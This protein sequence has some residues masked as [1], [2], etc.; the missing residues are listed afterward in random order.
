MPRYELTKDHYLQD[1][2][3]KI[4]PQLHEAGSKV[5]WEGP[6]SLHMKPL[7]N[8]ATERVE[9]RQAA[10][11][12]KREKAQAGRAMAGWTPQFGANMAQIITRTTSPEAPA[13]ADAGSGRKKKAA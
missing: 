11:K 9:A 4:E 6:V 7:D 2:K 13:Q 5:E 3:R 10:F 12:E 8:E 1:K